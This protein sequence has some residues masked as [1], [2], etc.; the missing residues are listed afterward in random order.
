MTATDE[1]GELLFGVGLAAVATYVA[2]RS[3]GPK[4]AVGTLIVGGIAT[5]AASTLGE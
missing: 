4:A 5:G 1:R 3:A 2:Y